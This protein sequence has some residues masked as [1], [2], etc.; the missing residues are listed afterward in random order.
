MLDRIVGSV[1]VLVHVLMR[2][3]LDRHG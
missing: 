1:I 2:A 3:R